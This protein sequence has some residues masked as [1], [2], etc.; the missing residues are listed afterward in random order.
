MFGGGS[1]TTYA[2]IN[3]ETITEDG[4]FDVAA[5]DTISLVA[6]TKISINGEWQTEKSYELTVETPYVVIGRTWDYL[7]V[8]TAESLDPVKVIIR[9]T[10]TSKNYA[11]L[12]G[13]KLAD[14]LYELEVGAEI[15]VTV[16]TSGENWWSAPF[17]YLNGQ[18]V[19]GPTSSVSS[20]YTFNYYAIRNATVACCKGYANGMVG[21]IEL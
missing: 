2:V 19:A 5:G 13:T 11:E 10:N 14:G 9:G 6:N 17:I 12:D 8:S 18:Q 20:K 21:I 3:G 1:S 4:T 16:K 7:Y 15:A